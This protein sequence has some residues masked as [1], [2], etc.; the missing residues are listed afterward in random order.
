[1]LQP[2][3]DVRSQQISLKLGWPSGDLCDCQIINL[4]QILGIYNQVEISSNTSPPPQSAHC[5]NIAL[6]SAIASPSGANTGNS[7]SEGLNRKRSLHR[8]Q[9]FQSYQAEGESSGGSGQG[10][11]GE[12]GAFG[13]GRTS[14]AKGSFIK[15]RAVGNLHYTAREVM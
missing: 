4:F 11:G 13:C 2:T 8:R 3:F 15:S 10:V 14:E 6:S 5:L 7:G 12:V 1:M 9:K